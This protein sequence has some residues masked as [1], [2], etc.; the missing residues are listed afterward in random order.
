MLQRAELLLLHF[1]FV[2]HFSQFHY[3]SLAGWTVFVDC[4][5][6]SVFIQ[7]SHF[8]LQQYAC[9]QSNRKETFANWL[10]NTHVPMATGG[11]Q[12]VTDLSV[13]LCDWR[14]IRLILHCHHGCHVKCQIVKVKQIDNY[15]ARDSVCLSL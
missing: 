7:S 10:G 12:M 6:T 4:A 13:D 15:K 11:C 8:T 9:N 3:S 14:L 2:L 1:W 5:L